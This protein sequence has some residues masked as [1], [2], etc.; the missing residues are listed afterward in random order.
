MGSG[1]GLPPMDESVGWVNENL[2]ICIIQGE[3]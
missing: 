3:G 1:C 2:K